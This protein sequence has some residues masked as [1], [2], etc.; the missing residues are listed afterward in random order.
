MKRE[1]LRLTELEIEQ[2]PHPAVHGVNLLLCAGEC[3]ILS[4]GETSGKRLL[5]RFFAGMIPAARG[6][7]R[8][9]GQR[10]TGFAPEQWERA[11]HVY[12]LHGAPDLLR[13][14]DLAENFFMM[15][16][17]RLSK[18]L[19]NRRAMHLRTA[20][21]LEE[22]GLSY[23]AYGS[24]ERL[25][26]MDRVMLGIAR[27]VDQ[28]ARLLVL[29]DIS[30]GL[31]LPQVDRLL[32]LLRRV[33]QCGVGILLVDSWSGWFESVAD[34]MVLMQNGEIVKKMR[35]EDFSQ[36]EKILPKPPLPAPQSAHVQEQGFELVLEYC[37]ATVT[38]KFTFG[39]ITLLLSEDSRVLDGCWQAL[40]GGGRKCCFRFDGREIYCRNPAVLRAQRIVLWG[41]RGR[42]ALLHENLTI[43]ENI[44]LPSLRRISRG[45]FFCE[46]ARKILTDRDFWGDALDNARLEQRA[47]AYQWETL[48]CRWK[49]FHPRVLVLYGLLSA[50]GE[51]T[52]R[53]L[54]TQLRELC[55]RGTAVILLETVERDWN[56]L[57]D[58]VIS[59]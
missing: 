29:E 4:G 49:L 20:Q 14:M 54:Y 6:N 37:G 57:A 10:V 13:C 17:T 22:L 18:L 42:A 39:Q 55:R 35:P 44:L 48:L 1:L 8:V 53:Q 2:P 26:R 34:W 21:A 59:I 50:V 43:A 9:E 32:E 58:R 51:E 41:R 31:S 36:K 47:P 16:R 33:K 25:T 52:Q 15:R 56:G 3:C 7:V 40:Q 27:A 45:P 19:L 38:E 24:V 23:E 30:E 28:G 11:R 5:A 12:Y 46:S